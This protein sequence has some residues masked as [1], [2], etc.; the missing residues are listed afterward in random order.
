MVK[1]RRIPI[2]SHRGIDGERGK[3]REQF[4]RQSPDAQ[5]SALRTLLGLHR[6]PEDLSCYPLVGSTVTCSRGDNDDDP[7]PTACDALR[8]RLEALALYHRTPLEIAMPEHGSLSSS[9]HHCKSTAG[10]AQSTA[11]VRAIMAT[12]PQNDCGFCVES[13][14]IRRHRTECQEIVDWQPHTCSG[15]GTNIITTIFSDRSRLAVEGSDGGTITLWTDVDFWCRIVRTCPCLSAECG[16]NGGVSLVRLQA[17]FQ[18]RYGMVLPPSTREF[19]Q[20]WSRVREQRHRHSIQNHVHSITVKPADQQQQQPDRPLTGTPT[21]T[22]T[23]ITTETSS[24]PLAST[25]SHYHPARSHKRKRVASPV[26]V[27]ESWISSTT[28]LSIRTLPPNKLRRQWHSF[29]STLQRAVSPGGLWQVFAKSPATASKVA[30]PAAHAGGG[31]SS[32]VS[33]ETHTR[34]NLNTMPESMG[35]A[36]KPTRPTKENTSTSESHGMM[37]AEFQRS[38][39]NSAELDTKGSAEISSDSTTPKDSLKNSQRESGGKMRRTYG[40]RNSD[41]VAGGS[42]RIAHELPSSTSSTSGRSTKDVPEYVD[43]ESAHI[44]EAKL[45]SK[46]CSTNGQKGRTQHTAAA[47]RTAHLRNSHRRSRS[48]H[49]GGK[50]KHQYTPQE[51]QAVAAGDT[52]PRRVSLRRT[53]RTRLEDCVP[54]LKNVSDTI[55]M[56]SPINEISHPKRRHRTKQC[57]TVPPFCHKTRVGQSLTKP[58]DTGEALTIPTF[59]DVKLI[60]MKAGYTFASKFFARPTSCGRQRVHGLEWFD[61]EMAFRKHLCAFGVD[62]DCNKW[63]K[64]EK[65]LVERWVRYDIVDVSCFSRELNTYDLITPH[66][67]MQLLYRLGCCLRCFNPQDLYVL[68]EVKKGQEILGINSFYNE[69]DLC[70]HLAR[71]GLPRSEKTKLMDSR[72]I[73]SLQLFLSEPGDLLDTF[74]RMEQVSVDSAT[75]AHRN[76]ACFDR[77]STGGVQHDGTSSLPTTSRKCASVHPQIKETT[78]FYV[79][80]MKKRTTALGS[81]LFREYDALVALKQCEG[82]NFGESWLSAVA[83]IETKCDEI[84]QHYNFES[85]KKAVISAESKEWQKFERE[86]G[87]KE[88]QERYV[89]KEDEGIENSVFGRRMVSGQTTRAT[90]PESISFLGKAVQQSVLF[91]KRKKKSPRKRAAGFVLPGERINTTDQLVPGFRKLDLYD[92]CLTFDNDSNANSCNCTGRTLKTMARKE[93]SY[94]ALREIK[95]AISF[96]IDYDDAQSEV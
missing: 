16:R 88:D 68:P 63:D 36:Q 81:L 52:H 27:L 79:V 41:R 51:D 87:A 84:E 72:D 65:A 6:K 21:P 75:A 49:S 5:D 82:V 42:L 96:L 47:E 43:L 24:T 55:T 91:E 67:A 26:S 61:S 48:E 20:T 95:A 89:R 7:F 77:Q 70:V 69:N 40:R 85:M 18:K 90:E 78:P 38:L 50:T 34:S 31:P 19:R 74:E 64:W 44:N 3:Q 56:D 1:V 86:M 13:R 22:P 28:T 17:V 83:A 9:T 35:V 58:N 37:G 14:P 4:P 66:R 54:V 29:S 93:A 39:E 23:K 46:S 33:K 15:P 12:C 32:S 2:R 80:P 94:I 53:A 76:A 10:T 71:F 30:V 60:L 8:F 73:L 59:E 25:R 62:G 45:T 57:I 11:R 92:T